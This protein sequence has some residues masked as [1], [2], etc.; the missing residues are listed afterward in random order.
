MD[1]SSLY[2]SFLTCEVSCHGGANCHLRY[3]IQVFL[4]IEP[5]PDTKQK[6]HSYNPSDSKSLIGQL[7]LRV[8]GGVKD[9]VPATAT[10]PLTRLSRVQAA[11]HHFKLT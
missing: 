8:T 1:Q 9:P 2:R 11:P 7:W 10:P 3:G 5:K 4:K 6:G